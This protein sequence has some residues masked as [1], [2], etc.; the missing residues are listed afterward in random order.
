MKKI[1][2]SPKLPAEQRRGQLLTAAHRLFADKGY[3]E[4]STEE[5]ARKAGLTKGALYFHFKSKE[6]ILFALIKMMSETYRE[7]MAGI[8]YRGCEPGT[9]LNTLMEKCDFSAPTEFRSVLDIWVQALRVPRIRR[10]INENH[11]ERVKEFCRAVQPVKGWKRRQLEQFAIMTFSLADGLSA[12]RAL[13]IALVDTRIQAQLFQS[14][15]EAGRSRRREVY[16]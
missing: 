6:D 8:I 16:K 3:R 14:M 11:R 9:I 7:S 13:D 1:K 12:H 5:I 2:Q 15:Y 10:Y 4:T